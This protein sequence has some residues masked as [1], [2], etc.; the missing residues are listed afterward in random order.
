MSTTY[1]PGQRISEYLLQER[2]GVGSFAEVW[3]ARHHIWESEH[4]AIKLPV[5]P[6]Y[7]RYLQR[8]GVVVHG[9]K[10]SNVVRV[11][12]FDPYAETPYLIMELVKGPALAQV[13]KENAKGL[14]VAAIETIL[15]GVL[16]G[17]VAAQANQVLHRDL[18][19][20]NV[21]LNLD[22][23]GLGSV[24]LEDV[25][26]VDF[27]LGLKNVDSLRSIVQ[28][29]SIDRDSKLVGTLAYMAPELR[30]GH[31]AADHRSDLYSVGVMLFEMLTGER[32]AGAEMPSEMR[33]ET[34]P[35]MDAIFQRLYA[36]YERR[37]ESAQAVLDDLDQR[38][39]P[40]RTAP[41]ITPQG[42]F[43][44]SELVDL[45]LD[46]A[47][48]NKIEIIKL[49][50]EARPDLGLAEAKAIADGA[51]RAVLERVDAFNA[52]RWRDV[53]VAHGASATMIRSAARRGIGMEV[54]P[55]PGSIPPLPG[56]G[57]VN[58]CRSCNHAI[59]GDD[60]FCTQCGA[61]VVERVKRCRECGGFP[62]PRDQFCIFCGCPLGNAVGA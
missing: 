10:H 34:P 33:R 14:P 61:Q 37:Y 5:E 13:L 12:G 54:P 22:G 47:G 1:Q 43:G 28:S 27:G 6:E 39:R 35:G 52:E 38:M 9:I 44:G 55:I 56:A 26:L 23:K 25:K 62:G 2:I 60:Q 51:G 58:R 17:M 46:S 18:K 24:A 40:L 57:R 30:D 3:R 32:P 45:V 15:R 20:G 41:P 7:V 42:V 59:E 8:E 11:L 4:V 29:A 50:R 49:I 36:R 16:A 21:L 53:F 19:P 48:R 31:Q